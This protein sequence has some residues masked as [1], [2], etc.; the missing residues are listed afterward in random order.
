MSLKDDLARELEDPSRPPPSLARRKLDWYEGAVVPM[1]QAIF[2]AQQRAVV[3]DSVAEDGLVRE[4]AAAVSRDGFEPRPAPSPPRLARWL[5]VW[6]EHERAVLEA[7]EEPSSAR[8]RRTL[9]LDPVVPKQR[10]EE[11]ARA[12]RREALG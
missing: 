11:M 5:D 3:I 12:V 9:E 8:I 2:S 6:T 10:L 1:L 7:V 4:H